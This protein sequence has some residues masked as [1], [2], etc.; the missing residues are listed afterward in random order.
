M[1]V[2]IY[3]GLRLI[4]VRLMGCDFNG[5]H[6]SGQKSPFCLSHDI[7]STFVVCPCGRKNCVKCSHY[8]ENCES[9][10]LSINTRGITASRSI[11][12]E[13]IVFDFAF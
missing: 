13:I 4:H 6:S 11:L 8:C 5:K 9:L 2:A 12:K 3:Q 7:L 10:L 1:W